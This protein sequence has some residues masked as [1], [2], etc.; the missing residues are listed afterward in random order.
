MPRASV[1][2]GAP[3]AL[4]RDPAPFAAFADVLFL[5]GDRPFSLTVLC[6]QSYSATILVCLFVDLPRQ[7]HGAGFGARP[8]ALAR[9]PGVIWAQGGHCTDTVRK[10]CTRRIR[11][12]I[13]DLSTLSRQP[14]SGR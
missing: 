8:G 12:P 6:K 7:Y 3:V 5:Y 13:E 10:A 2:G 4:S 11:G 14:G 1:P 9:S